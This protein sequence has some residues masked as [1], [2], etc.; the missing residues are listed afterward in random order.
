MPLPSHLTGARLFGVPDAPSILIT[1][2]VYFVKKM[3]EFQ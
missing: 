1:L 3:A 2:L